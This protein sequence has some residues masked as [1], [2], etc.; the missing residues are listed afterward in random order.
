LANRSTLDETV[1][2]KIVLPL[3]SGLEQVHAAGFIHRN[4]KPDNIFLRED[5]SPVLLDFGSARQSIG[6][7]T[8]PLTSIVSPGYA[9]FEQY[10]SKSDEQGPWTDIYGL[11]ATMYRAIC[12]RAPTDAVGRSRTILESNQD[13]LV[14]ALEIGAGN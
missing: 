10:Y 8:N 14:S 11:A 5:G 3:L 9:P 4:I 7:Q 6:Q 12:G 13:Y 2:L 1:L